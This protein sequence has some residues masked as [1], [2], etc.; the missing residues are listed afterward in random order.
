ME[1]MLNYKELLKEQR[2]LDYKIKVTET[3]IGLKFLDVIKEAVKETANYYKSMDFKKVVKSSNSVTVHLKDKDQIRAFLGPDSHEDVF[4]KRYGVPV[5][6]DVFA[7]K[8]G[9]GH[10]NGKRFYIIANTTKMKKVHKFNVN[11]STIDYVHRVKGYAK[12]DV[13]YDKILKEAKELLKQAK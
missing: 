2:L 10:A 7:E 1:I 6:F 8:D 3:L 12:D 13:K 9:Y 5:N 4:I 11:N